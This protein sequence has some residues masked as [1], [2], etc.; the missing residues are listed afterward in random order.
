MPHDGDGPAPSE[1]AVRAV[2]RA[3]LDEQGDLA[4]LAAW[5]VAACGGARAAS[6]PPLA[7]RVVAALDD[8]LRALR[9][10]LRRLYLEA[11]RHDPG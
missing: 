7:C 11:E 2:L 4:D 9:A 6:A 1:L 3:Y 5:L 8:H 10:E